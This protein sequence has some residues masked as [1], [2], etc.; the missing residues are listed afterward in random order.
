MCTQV[1]NPGA[2][3]AARKLQSGLPQL[4]VTSLPPKP[5]REAEA[6]RSQ[7]SRPTAAAR[8]GSRGGLFAHMPAFLRPQGPAA[9]SATASTTACSPPP[10]PPATPHSQHSE[11]QTC[12]TPGSGLSSDPFPLLDLP[13][14][15]SRPSRSHCRVWSRSPRTSVT[16]SSGSE[17]STP[18]RSSRAEKPPQQEPTVFLL[19][20]NDRTYLGEEGERL[21]EELRAARD[22]GFQLLMLHENDPDN[23]GCEFGTC[24]AAWQESP[25]PT[26]TVRGPGLT[27]ARASQ[28]PP[29]GGVGLAGRLVGRP[30]RYLN[31]SAGRPLSAAQV[32]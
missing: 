4:V 3:A 24:F 9:S 27:A 6:R 31:H 15:S 25:R 21:I 29:P 1:N 30:H 23:G 18:R 16:S 14:A 13:G 11:P 26:A 19:Y 10:S 28:S 7:H 12:K 17:G 8:G 20:L 22:E 32:L 5:V 2:R